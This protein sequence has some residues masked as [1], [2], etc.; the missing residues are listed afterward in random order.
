MNFKALLSSL[1]LLCFVSACTTTYP[2]VGS[3]DNYNEVFLGEINHDLM[4]GKAFIEIE[5]KTT[6]IRCTGGSRVEY[7]PASNYIAGAFLIPYCAGQ[8]GSADLECNDGNFIKA[9]WTAETCT[10]GYGYGHDKNGSRFQFAFGM[11][12]KEALQK[13]E[14]EGA[15]AQSKPD[16][17][18]YRPKESRKEIGFST[19]TGFL[20]TSDGYLLT[21]FHVVEDAKEIFI[22]H[23]GKQYTAIIVKSDPLHD[24]ALL[25]TLLRG[26]PVTVPPYAQIAV[27]EEVMTLGYP[28]V[29]IQGQALKAS[30]GRVNALSGIADDLRF[31]QIDVPIQPGNSGGPLINENGEL[32]GIVTATLDQFVVLKESGTLPQNVN[33]AV[34]ANYV[35]PLIDGLKGRIRSFDT[36][37]FKRLVKRYG[38]SVVLVVAK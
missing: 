26:V 34:K 12:E 24:V 7:I 6:G 8:K 35:L 31:I 27:A 38:N 25:K 9:T 19:G 18:G 22:L 5:A 2:V 36:S 16:L 13:F 10:K 29:K 37:G 17:P 20:V 21:N 30:F 4:A 14:S 11:S 33:Y 32:V 28:L 23:G 1:V 15:L 3:I